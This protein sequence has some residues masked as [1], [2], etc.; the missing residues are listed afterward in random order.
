MI[1]SINKYLKNN[2]PFVIQGILIPIKI[3]LPNSM[4]PTIPQEI[5]SIDRSQTNQPKVGFNQ[6]NSR[7]KHISYNRR[8]DYIQNIE[9][10]LMKKYRVG[11]SGLHKLL[12]LKEG[13]F[14]L[15]R[16]FL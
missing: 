16:P 10:E 13:N 6:E 14:H 12:V 5:N 4:F 2:N 11:Y 8:E 15:T 1:K 7:K 3:N 9:E